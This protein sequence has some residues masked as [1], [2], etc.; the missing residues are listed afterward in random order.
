MDVGLVLAKKAEEMHNVRSIPERPARIAAIL[1]KLSESGRL[2]QLTHVEA[3]PASEEHVLLTHSM[4]Y[5]RDFRDSCVNGR[6]SIV[7]TGA[8]GRP[9]E[10]TLALLGSY[11]AGTD[12]AV[13]NARRILDR[14]RQSAAF[15]TPIVSTTYEAS[16]HSAGTVLSAIEAVEKGGPRRVFCLTRPPGHHAEHEAALGFCYFNNIAIGA[17]FLLD[18]KNVSRVA[19]VDFD[20]HHGNGTQHLFYHDPRVLVV[21]IHRDPALDGFY[22]GFCGHGHEAGAGPGHGF[23]V[24]IPLAAGS[25]NTAYAKA[26]DRGLKRVADFEPEWL[27]VS[28]GFDAHKADP[29]GKMQLRSKDFTTFARRLVEIA[30]AY[31]KGR[32]VSVLEGGYNLGALSASVDAYLNGLLQS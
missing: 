18:T 9:N 32:M 13:E 22:P 12:V 23:N 31:C 10:R 17:D 14:V 3:T 20:V 15:D 4:S 16:L 7:Y 27:L 28:A 29:L 21:N 6:G 11:S 24:N 19:I 5:L 26:F 8:D 2:S 1:S 25:D 30:D